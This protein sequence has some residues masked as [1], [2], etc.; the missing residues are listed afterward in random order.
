MACAGA[1]RGRRAW[2]RRAAAPVGPM[3]TRA[4][5][6]SRRRPRS[7]GPAAPPGRRRR[8]CAAPGQG[9]ARTT[10]GR[11][12]R[13]GSPSQPRGPRR[14]GPTRS[15][16]PRSSWRRP[17]PRT[18][19]CTWW[20]TSGTCSS[21][22][23]TAGCGPSQTDLASG[24][25]GVG[26]GAGWLRDERQDAG[27]AARAVDELQH[28]HEDPG[29]QGRQGRQ[30]LE[31]LEVPQAARMADLCGGPRSPPS[32]PGSMPRVSMPRP[33]TPRSSTR[34][35]A[36]SGPKPGNRSRPARPA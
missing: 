13:A 16:A 34:K 8:L 7:A 2:A 33:T 35:R 28:A 9:A 10:D 1:P 12:S 20:S 27:R 22:S 36:A 11:R 31:T 14:V 17:V 25:T 21:A 32:C 5:S 29:T 6:R 19:E 4:G 15:A 30:V 24:P 23:L 26:R 18:M 3:S